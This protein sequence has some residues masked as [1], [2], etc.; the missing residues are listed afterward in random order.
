MQWRLARK[1]GL[2][3]LA[4]VLAIALPGGAAYG[5]WAWLDY[6]FLTVTDGQVY[7]S[8]AMPPE[9]L[10]ERVREHGIRT[11]IDLRSG[12]KAVE[13]ERDALAAIGV[14]H[15]NVPSGQVPADE[16]VDAFLEIMR[17][18]ENRPVLIHCQ[19][20]IGRAT[21]YSAI[22]RME[23]EGWSNEQ[24]RST[25]YWR[26]GLGSFEAGDSKGRFL[27][28]YTPRSSDDG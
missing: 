16:R 3:C 9:K 1:F 5:Y 24:A 15:H 28:D 11:V 14:R 17:Q 4:L 20:G 12:G 26:S 25:A 19:H 8:G 10:V 2:C 18:P 21:L 7:R 23:L 27:L 13:A 22:Y 6:R